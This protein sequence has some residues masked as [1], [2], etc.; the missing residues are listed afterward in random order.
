MG[1]T[2]KPTYA[3]KV[4]MSSVYIHAS[5]MFWLIQLLSRCKF[6]ILDISG[7]TDDHTRQGVC[8]I[9]VAAHHSLIIATTIIIYQLPFLCKL[10]QDP[11]DGAWFINK[12]CQP[13]DY[14]P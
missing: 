13:C 3:K 1:S 6:K 2:N 10:P 5:N 7:N 9:V 11:L 8:F 4:V 14:S 12:H